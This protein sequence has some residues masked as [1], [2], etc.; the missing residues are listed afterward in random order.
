MEQSRRHRDDADLAALHVENLWAGIA[1]CCRLSG[2]SLLW[3]AQ[4]RT[5]RED[6]GDPANRGQS[7]RGALWHHRPGNLLFALPLTFAV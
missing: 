6:G 5:E 4:R 1:R 3:E 7:H 2:L